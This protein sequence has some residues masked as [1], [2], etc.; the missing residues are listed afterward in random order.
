MGEGCFVL[1]LPLGRVRNLTLGKVCRDG[2]EEGTMR[3]QGS[4][5]EGP[6]VRRQGQHLVAGKAPRV[7]QQARARI[8]R[9]SVTVCL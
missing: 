5:V 8:A 7:E 2:G 4:G 3:G 6:Q 1:T 9:R